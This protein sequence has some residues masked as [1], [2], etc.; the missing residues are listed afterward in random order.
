[1]IEENSYSFF[2]T[3]QAGTDGSRL[4]LGGVNPK[5]A[6]GDFKYYDLAHANYWMI[7]MDKLSVN[8]TNATISNLFGIVDTGTSVIVGPTALVKQITAA[9]P[10]VINCTDF[11]GYPN[12][13]FTI[14]GD[15][16]VLTPDDYILK[17][18]IMG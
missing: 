10:S 11:S 13:V 17:I 14:G 18:T 15:D 1:M 6:A 5:Y 4:V 7:A 12:L 2:L 3:K 9:L 16:Y 8:G